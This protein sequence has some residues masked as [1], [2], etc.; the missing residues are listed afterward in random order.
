VRSRIVGCRDGR[1]VWRFV[2]AFVGLFVAFQL[3][4]YE[5]IVDSA[6]FNAYVAA[7]NRLAAGALSLGG[8]QATA[9]GNVLSAGFS[10]SVRTGCDG[11]Q[12]MGVLAI[13]VALLPGTPTRK[14]IGILAGI[15][16][17]A[18]LNTVRL[19]SLLWTGAHFPDYFQVLHVHVW[20]GLL[21][22]FAVLYAIAWT[23]WAERSAFGQK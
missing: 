8:Q 15:V 11:I 16:A 17:I 12:T 19:A 21:V 6:P 3:A 20:P 10:M 18:L 9:S 22:V 7:G 1:S 2:A 23:K 4:Y 5:F 13:A 14:V